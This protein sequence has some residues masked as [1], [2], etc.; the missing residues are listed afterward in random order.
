MKWSWRA[1]AGVVLALIAS[2]LAGGA[3]AAPKAELWN[4]WT[5]HAPDSKT[6]IDHSWWTNFLRIYI[7]AGDDGINRFAYG[8]VSQANKD[9]LKQYVTGL[10]SLP[11]ER[12]NRDEQFAYWVN[13]YNALSVDVILDHYPVKSVL[14][15]SISPGWFSIGPWGKKLITIGGEDISLNDIE[16]RILRPI[17]RDPRAHYALNCTALS[18]PN[19]LTEAF[20]GANT[21][22]ML[23]VAAWDYINRDGVIT[24][25]DD[26]LVVSS[27][28]EWYKADFGGDDASLITH[29]MLYAD[30]E[31]AAKLEGVSEIV[32][33]R[34]NWALNDVKD[35]Q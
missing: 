9:A 16:H 3:A 12:Y 33:H 4:H 5:V 25:D 32:D 8:G 21:G 13:L 1:F 30:G 19:L 26:G 34:Y 14:K 28:F 7:E 18:C 11:I 17:W 27:I 24:T 31:L 15:I 10:A 20:T 22:G 35:D 2:P 6:V 23:D 29:L